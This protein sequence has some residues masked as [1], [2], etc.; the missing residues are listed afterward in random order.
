[1]VFELITDFLHQDYNDALVNNA[2]G[3]ATNQPPSTY[4]N[5][6]PKPYTPMVKSMTFA[7]DAESH[8]V[9]LMQDKED[10]FLG[11]DVEFFHISAFGHRREHAFL[12][13]EKQ[14]GFPTDLNIRLLP[15]NAY[16]GQF[17]IG[18]KGIEPG[19]HL[20]L[21]F[22]MARVELPGRRVEYSHG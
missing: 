12:K 17:Y 9:N 11:N 10:D 2:I 20:P 19:Q 14:L 4:P 22:Q 18:I 7:Y 21:L 16:S 1:M 15:Y 5:I 8:T 3:K 13:H 6:P